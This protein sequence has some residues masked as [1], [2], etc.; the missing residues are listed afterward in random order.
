MQMMKLVQGL[1]LAAVLA[2]AGCKSLDITNPNNPDGPRALADP[3]AIEAVAGGSIRIWINTYEQLEA[4]GPLVT[5]AQTYSASWNN[6]NMNFY[7]SIDADGTRN[8]R[9]WQ[10]NP[11]ASART[12]IEAYWNGYY[13]SLGLANSVLKAIRVNG[14]VINNAPDTKRAETI[15]QLM[16]GASLSGIA[17]NY[18]KGYILDENSDLGALAYSN[19]KQVRDAALAAFDT[20]IALATANTFTT[21][22]GWANG[23]IYTNVQVAKIA[24]TMAAWLLANYPRSAAENTAVDWARVVTYASNGMSVGTRFD[25]M[26]IGDGCAAWC[27]EVIYWF[28]SIDT[29]RLSTRVARLLS[30]AQVHPYPVG[31]NPQPNTGN[32]PDRRLGDGSFGS[33]ALTAGFGTVPRT[34]NGGSDFAYSTQAIFNNARGTYH[35]SNIAHVRYDAS[36]QQSPTSIYGGNGPAPVFSAAQNDLLWAEGLLRQAAPNLATAAT[37]IN[38]TRVTRGGLTPAAAGDGA[39]VLMT[40]LQYEMEIELLGLGASSYYLRRRI[41]GLL[42]GTPREMPVPAKELGVFGQPLYTWGGSGPANSPTPP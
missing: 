41:D 35:Q 23:P 17:M 4:G 39:T 34:V 8:S 11:A 38:N 26:F 2:A 32:S 36:G 40:R 9:P 24:R 37:L 21:P 16:Q 7:S 27:A 3:A 6:F 13:S 15:A 29:G 12:S 31:G 10:N 20:T 19:R 33:A 18:D 22:S 14:L 42:A 28:N 5:Q 30:A 1:G 25:F